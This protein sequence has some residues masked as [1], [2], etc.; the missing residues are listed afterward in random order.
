M[1]DIEESIC[2]RV[3]YCSDSEDSTPVLPFTCNKDLLI[4]NLREA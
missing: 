4:S 3:K 1:G 2:L